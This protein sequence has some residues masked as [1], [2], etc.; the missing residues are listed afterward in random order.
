MAKKQ[1][2]N[3]PDIKCKAG[4]FQLSCWKDSKIIPAKNDYDIEREF[5]QINICLSVG[6]KRNGEWK[7]MQAWF[8]SSQFGNL[9]DVVDDFAEK[10]NELNMG[11]LE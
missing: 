11:G 4:V 2:N 6:M 5:E 1:K 8:R 7:N 3:K 9:K 10:L